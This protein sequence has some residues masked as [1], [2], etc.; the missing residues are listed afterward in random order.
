M[1]RI[2]LNSMLLRLAVTTMTLSLMAPLAGCSKSADEPAAENAALATP[3]PPGMIR[4]TVLE[5]MNSGGYTYVFMDTGQDQRWV[6][7]METPVQVGDV[8]QTDQGM[9]M[10]G[11]TSKT[12]NRTFNV[13]YFVSGLQNLSGGTQPPAQA[14]GE[15]PT[16]HPDISGSGTEA[17]AVADIAAYEEGKDIAYVYAN[18]DDL[19][20]QPVTLRGKVVKYNTGILGWNFIHIQDGSGDA[21]A[22]SNDLIVT[23]KA[24]TAVGDVVV[25]SGT[26]VL[27]K[28]FGAGYSYP[29]LLE[30]ASITTE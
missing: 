13:V 24:E 29:V 10:S 5:T 7:A 2:I 8:V 15:L 30:D 11:F 1:W 17:A 20:G 16:G 26:I 12:L 23:S 28:D 3:V 21:G 6:A 22:G 25:L 14:S 27:D 18:K 9:A 4:G 19:A